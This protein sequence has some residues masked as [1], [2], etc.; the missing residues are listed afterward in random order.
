MKFI[1]H[2]YVLGRFGVLYSLKARINLSLQLLGVLQ[3]T[4]KRNVKSIQFF[5]KMR[6]L[7]KIDALACIFPHEK[8]RGQ[9]P[10]GHRRSYVL[11]F[12]IF[13]IFSLFGYFWGFK[14]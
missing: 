8:K 14:L 5:Q 11:Y 3:C 4:E 10:L 12:T 9:V 7:Q 1:Q 13:T 6:L 2:C